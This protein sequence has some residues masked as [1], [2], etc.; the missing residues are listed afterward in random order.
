MAKVLSCNAG[1]S[2][3]KVGT[4]LPLSYQALQW[5]NAVQMEQRRKHDTVTNKGPCSNCTL[6]VELNSPFE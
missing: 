6:S 5:E 3:H 4:I 1:K 2:V